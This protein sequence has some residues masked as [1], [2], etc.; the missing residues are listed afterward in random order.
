[1]EILR[2]DA[3]AVVGRGPRFLTASL[4]REMGILLVLSMGF[5]FMLHLLPVPENSQ[6]GPRL[7]P[8]FWAPL[9]GCLW[10]RTT[11][12]VVV[13]AVAPWLNWLFTRHPV[14]PVGVLMTI[15]LL[16]FVGTLRG[17]LTWT[18]VRHV[19]ALP[20]YAAAMLVATGMVALWPELGRGAPALA[21]VGRAVTM[22]W[23]GV[24][25]LVLINWLALRAYPPHRGDGPLA[26]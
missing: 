13:A 10:G 12:A 4:A 11:T 19:A 16:V 6:L 23:P 2:L 25:I 22:A 8:M 14:P 24:L 20:A 3:S 15:Q 5:P 7:L 17:L 26:A 9:L 21:W 1:M 18:P